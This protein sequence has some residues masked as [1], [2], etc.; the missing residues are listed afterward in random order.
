MTENKKI[1]ILYIDDEE[2]SLKLFKITFGKQYDI[3]TAVNADLGLEIIKSGEDF[4]MLFSDMKMPGKSG[5]EFIAMAKD[6]KPQLPSI[7][8]TG[9]GISA[10]IKE[11]LNSGLIVEYVMKPFN[12]STI[13]RLIEKFA[14]S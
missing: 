3:T 1:K 10:P 4:D 7:L 2:I 14:N 5:L 13:N 12:K 6:I 9:Y 11:A 8:I